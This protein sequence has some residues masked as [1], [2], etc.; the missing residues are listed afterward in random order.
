M[1]FH[2]H[3]EFSL[4]SFTDYF[5]VD[6]TDSGNEYFLCLGFPCKLHGQVFLQHLCDGSE[7]LLLV[8]L[9]GSHGIRNNR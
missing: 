5:Q 4:D 9:F 7:Q 2:F 6:L 3:A 1:Q 8:A